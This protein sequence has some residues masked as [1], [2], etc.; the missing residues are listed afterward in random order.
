MTPVEREAMTRHGAYIR[1]LIERGTVIVAGPVF[2]PNGSWGLCV[3]TAGSDGDIRDAMDADPVVAA[4]LG[5]SYD[6]HP[7][8]SLLRSESG[9]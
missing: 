2:D 4:G 1:S 9:H 7:M 3:A 8:P 6:I 5:F